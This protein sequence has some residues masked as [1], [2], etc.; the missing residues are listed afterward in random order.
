M[1]TRRDK[2][3]SFPAEIRQALAEDDLDT[4]EGRLDYQDERHEG[5]QKL[6]I[7]AMVS[8][9]MAAIG[10]AIKVALDSAGK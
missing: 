1:T 3:H 2:R 7:G 9:S 6:L 5:Q 10:I 4:H 8:F